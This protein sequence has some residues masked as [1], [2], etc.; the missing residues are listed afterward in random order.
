MA[1]ILCL[2]VLSALLQA[3]ATM[4]PQVATGP[5]NA[6][7]ESQTLVAVS[8][9]EQRRFERA[10]QAFAMQ[11]WPVAIAELEWLIEHNPRLSGP[12]LNLALVYQ[13]QAESEAAEHYFALA[14]EV[15]HGNLTAYN[16]YAVFLR[17]QGRFVEAESL[18]LQALEIS[19]Q[20]PITHFNLGILCDLY[21]GEEQRAL[22]HF[23]RYQ[24][25]T[26]SDNRKV[27]GWIIDLQRRQLTVV[28][29]G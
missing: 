26:E 3:C 29:G 24:E 19:E 9:A 13:Q 23:E 12:Y 16:Q 15:N 18:Y 5:A 21:L 1:R 6:G 7:S 22:L 25:L 17:E 2:I 20:D 28:Q 27:A 10:N 8:T 14:L 4:L 11:D